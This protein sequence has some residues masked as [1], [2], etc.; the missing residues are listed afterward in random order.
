ML[1]DTRMRR[2][3]FTVPLIEQLDGVY[4]RARRCQELDLL[5]HDFGGYVSE[6]TSID[7]EKANLPPLMHLV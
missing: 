2:N 1:K 7:D 5:H 3:M 6:T 4:R